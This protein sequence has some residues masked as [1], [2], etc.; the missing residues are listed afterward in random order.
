MDPTVDI[1]FDCLPLRS[2]GRLDVPLDASPLYR[3]RC[4]RLQAALDVHGAERTYFLYN[5]RCILR[6]ANSEVV[7]M[8]RF[9]FEGIVRTDAGDCQTDQVELEIHLANE[10]C[11]GIPAEVEAWLQQQVRQA[12]AI[13]FD[14]FISAGQLSDRASEVGQLERLS[15]LGGFAGMHL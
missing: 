6:F 3:Q 11:G 8:A 9:E 2:V 5:A 15:D 10:T 1:A 14:R 4:E 7:G 13:D 12:V